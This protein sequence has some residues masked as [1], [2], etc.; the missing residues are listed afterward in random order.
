MGGSAGRKHFLLTHRFLRGCDDLPK[1]GGA[2]TSQLGRGGIED[3][4]ILIVTIAPTALHLHR[5][6]VEASPTA[7]G[8]LSFSSQRPMA[9]TELRRVLLSGAFA[10]T[11]LG[12]SCSSED[13]SKPQSL[14]ADVLFVVVETTTM[15]TKRSSLSP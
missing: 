9:M 3:S 12:K 7:A 2:T 11:A 5:R 4:V 14:P 13:D 6:S 1:G 15:K 8:Q 10:A